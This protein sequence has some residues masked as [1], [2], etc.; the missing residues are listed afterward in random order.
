[1]IFMDTQGVS[2]SSQEVLA[3]FGLKFAK[4]KKHVLIVNL[5]HK[6]LFDLTVTFKVQFTFVF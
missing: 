3:C 4:P 5:Y 6:K 2:F 1:M